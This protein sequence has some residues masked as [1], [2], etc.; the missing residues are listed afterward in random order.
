ML[1]LQISEIGV[2][3]KRDKYVYFQKSNYTFTLFQVLFSLCHV[4][5]LNLKQMEKQQ[6]EYYNKR[7]CIKQIN[8]DEFVG[9][10]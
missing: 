10:V 1:E 7:H 5:V 9:K 6:T 8:Q 2:T 4:S 3:K